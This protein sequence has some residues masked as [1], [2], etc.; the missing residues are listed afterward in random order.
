MRFS[1]VTVME[2]LTYVS[3]RAIPGRRKDLFFDNE[4]KY[5][6]ITESINAPRKQ[7]TGAVPCAGSRTTTKK[8]VITTEYDLSQDQDGIKIAGA[9]DFLLDE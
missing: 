8:I 5:I 6:Q 3:A 7:R 1:D 2:P 4:K 9:V